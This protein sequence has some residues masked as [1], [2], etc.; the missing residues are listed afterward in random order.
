MSKFEQP[1]SEIEKVK[2]EITE[3][4]FEDGAAVLIGKKEKMPQLLEKLE[5]EGE[6][7]ESLGAYLKTYLELHKKIVLPADQISD[8]ELREWV[9]KNKS[10]FV[11]GLMPDKIHLQT[12]FLQYIGEDG[13][14]VAAN[15]VPEE[16]F[17]FQKK[18]AD[19]DF[20]VL[21][22]KGLYNLGFSTWTQKEK[23]EDRKLITEMWAKINDAKEN[24]KKKLEQEITEKKKEEFNF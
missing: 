3:E 7:M 14:I 9:S 4:G 20:D 10:N 15:I 23:P 16:I 18:G 13:D 2:K 17:N 19:L 12:Y 24:Y 21:V 8:N 6:L 22:R 5:K 11:G 1:D